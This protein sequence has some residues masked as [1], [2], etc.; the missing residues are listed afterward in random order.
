MNLPN[1]FGKI[2]TSTGIFKIFDKHACNFTKLFKNTSKN[3]HGLTGFSKK[4]IKMHD[5]YRFLPDILKMSVKMH[6]LNEI[7][8]HK[9]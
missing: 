7:C 2:S 4:P 3:A 1:F 9:T 6:G 8:G 5:K